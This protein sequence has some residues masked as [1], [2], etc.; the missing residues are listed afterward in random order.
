[1]LSSYPS[2]L[3][4]DYTIKNKWSQFSVEKPVPI[5]NKGKRKIEVLTANYTIS[6]PFK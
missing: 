1:M 3:L 2:D 6:N 5:S 4:S